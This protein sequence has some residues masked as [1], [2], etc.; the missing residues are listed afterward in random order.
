MGMTTENVP[1]EIMLALRRMEMPEDVVT[2]EQIAEWICTAMES[3]RTSAVWAERKLK[4]A[5]SELKVAEIE[6]GNLRRAIQST[7]SLV[8]P[9]DTGTSQDEEIR[10]KIIGLLSGTLQDAL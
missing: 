3:D 2:I 7:L 4:E 10:A 8:V 1:A 9:W 6:I 5:T